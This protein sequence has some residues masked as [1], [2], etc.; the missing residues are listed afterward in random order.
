LS[1][2]I[3]NAGR[4]G[5]FQLESLDSIA[6]FDELRT[7]VRDLLRSRRQEAAL[8]LLSR[9]PFELLPASNYF[10]DEFHVLH[11]DVS[12]ELYEEARMMSVAERA[13]AAEVAQT[14][15]ELARTFGSWPF[16]STPS[17]TPRNQ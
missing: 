16:T 8:R 3:Y 5:D 1:I 2:V 11:A 17:V 13:A 9:F 7:N 10:N 4:S 6:A 14:F 15:T 12:L